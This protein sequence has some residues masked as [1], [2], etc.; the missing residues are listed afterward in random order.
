MQRIWIWVKSPGVMAAVAI[1]SIALA[2]YQ[3]FFYERKPELTVKIDALSPVFD[4]HQPVGGLS[5]SYSGED[6]RSAKKALWVFKATISNTGN[7]ELKKGDYDEKAPWGLD[8]LNAQVVDHPTLVTS[9]AYLEKNLLIEAGKNSIKFSPV[10]FEPGDSAEITLLLLGPE[11]VKPEV[12]V[13]GKIAGIKSILLV[14]PNSPEDG[15]SV[16]RQAIRGDS[17]WVHLVRGVVYFI[18]TFAILI[19]LIVSSLGVSSAV[20]SLKEKRHKAERQ[21]RIREYRRHSELGKVSR[22]LMDVYMDKGADEFTRLA[23]AVEDRLEREATI[24]RLQES[25]VPNEVIQ[26]VIDRAYPTS[27]HF[28]NSYFGERIDK[29]LRTAKLLEGDQ[30]DEKLAKGFGDA[31]KDLA[32]FLKIDLKKRDVYEERVMV[33]QAMIEN[34]VRDAEELKA[35]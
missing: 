34:E 27:P 3:G 29:E 11:A 18:L 4:I 32:E 5:V 19:L 30:L 31:I 2:V 17:F 20:D 21:A 28:F 22:Y 1:F 12:R 7:A 25:A 35:R 9:N 26:P 23:R 16:W 10:I 14:G 24:A 6:L 13:A 15:L 8:V 33:R